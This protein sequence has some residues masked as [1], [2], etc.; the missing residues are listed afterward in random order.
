MPLIIL[1]WQMIILTIKEVSLMQYSDILSIIAIIVS[2]LTLVIE[3][4]IGKRTISV[5]LYQRVT[6]MFFSINEPFFSNPEMRPYFY[7]NLECENVDGEDYNRLVVTSEMILDTFEW[8]QHDIQSSKA[9][10]KT[11]WENYMMHIFNN[12]PIM[13]KLH[14]KH[15]EWHPCFDKLLQ[16]E[17]IYE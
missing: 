12:S 4:Y 5:S 16:R 8:I 7:E 1:F 6:E 11:S 10:D 15:P 3:F 14:S 9:E 17:N 13:R 2:C